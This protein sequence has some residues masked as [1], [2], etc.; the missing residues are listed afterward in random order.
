V[1]VQVD[2]V[3]DWAAV[4]DHPVDPLVSVGQLVDAEGGEAAVG[5]VVVLDVF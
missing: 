5:G 4:L 1:A 2:G 3:R